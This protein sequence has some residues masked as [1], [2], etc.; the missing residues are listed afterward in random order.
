MGLMFHSSNSLVGS[1]QGTPVNISLKRTG[2]PTRPPCEIF[3]PQP[4]TAGWDGQPAPMWT[5]C[6]PLVLSQSLLNPG[7]DHYL[8]PNVHEGGLHYT[9]KTVVL[10]D[11]SYGGHGWTLCRDTDVPLDAIADWPYDDS[12]FT[13]PAG[14]RAAWYELQNYSD[15]GSS[16][17]RPIPTRRMQEL[18]LTQGAKE[19]KV[20][21][22][23]YGL[24][25]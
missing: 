11:N 25:S 15:T 12:S 23:V 8:V 3:T 21:H 2:S 10:K 5:N 17:V 24:V 4:G 22:V 16:F 19:R 18:C 7:E 6:G 20:S 13:V 1:L 9:L 14:K